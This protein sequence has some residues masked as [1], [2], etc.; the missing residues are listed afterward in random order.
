MRKRLSVIISVFLLLFIAYGSAFAESVVYYADA[1][2]ADQGAAGTRTIKGL[3]TAIGS[4]KEATIVLA[5]NS[6]GDTTTY[7]VGTSFTVPSNITLKIDRGAVLQIATT[8][9]L[10]ISGHLDAGL[11]RW[12]SG[13]GAVTF[14]GFVKE[15]LPIWFGVT[16]DGTTDDTAAFQS[17]VTAVPTN[18][19]LRLPD[20]TMILS[21]I[22]GVSDMKIVGNKEVSILK[23][24]AA[25]ADHMIETSGDVEFD[26][27][28]I[29][30][31]KA[32]QTGRYAGIYHSGGAF[33][34]H[35]GKVT[36]TVK[37]GIAV[38][39]SSFV[40]V[41]DNQ[42]S[43]IADHGSSAGEVAYPLYVQADTVIQKIKIAN[44]D[45][46]NTPTAAATSPG[47]IMIN[48]TNGYI[49]DCY[50]AGNSLSGFGQTATSNW[51][52][53]I[54]VYK[55]AD[56]IQII[57]N[58]IRDYYYTPIVVTDSYNPIIIGNQISEP[59]YDYASNSG[60]TVTSYNHDTNEKRGA[61]ISGNTINDATPTVRGVAIYFAGTTGHLNQLATISNNNIINSYQGIQINY[62]GGGVSLTGNNVQT[63]TSYAVLIQNT[64]GEVSIVGG[65]YDSD[66]AIPIYARTAVTGLNLTISGVSIGAD[67]QSDGISIRN[68][69][70][71]N[72]QG[73]TINGTQSTAA[74]DLVTITRLTVANNICET[75]Y[76][77]GSATWDPDSIADGDEEVKEITV[78]GAALGDFC[79]ASFSLDVA[80]LNLTC[81]VTAAGTVTAQLNNNTGGAIDLASGTV[82]A[83]VSKRY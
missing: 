43:S 82:K 67:L 64:E 18:G 29:D 15:V 23:H 69:E 60:I 55:N 78:T 35:H 62:C 30:G 54:N 25:S 16:A 8:K 50:I 63:T 73:C 22:T 36:G 71:A 70:S 76:L 51:A 45:F 56:N 39:E 27:V 12:L 3:V 59:A 38:M 26:G 75:A 47:G 44:N 58:T 24:K 40:D 34:F 14:S 79:E 65:S 13:T 52:G 80:D 74:M 57:G 9:T 4:N 83:V 6:K 2:A 81:Q 33:I 72:I 28:Q 53:A 11:F 20:G 1:T 31:N 41:H 66:G 37:F 68:A 21:N 5:H 10:T 7:A 46:Q 17:A 19:T 42:F 49:K 61:V 77:S 32:N 48:A